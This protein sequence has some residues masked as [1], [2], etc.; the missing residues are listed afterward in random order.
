DASS[1]FLTPVH[2]ACFHPRFQGQK[3]PPNPERFTDPGTA[4]ELDALS[5]LLSDNLARHL[6]GELSVGE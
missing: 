4:I 3:S 6:Q 2:S 5:G 1:A